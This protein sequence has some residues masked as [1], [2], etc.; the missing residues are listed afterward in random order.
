M[1]QKNALILDRFSEGLSANGSIRRTI[2]RKLLMHL[3][4]DK[5]VIEYNDLVEDLVHEL[6]KGHQV[7]NF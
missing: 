4:T 3:S 7:L 1:F 2:R 6:H 5:S